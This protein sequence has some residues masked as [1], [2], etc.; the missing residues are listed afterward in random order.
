MSVS[1]ACG[2]KT[3][4]APNSL[5]Q[6]MNLLYLRKTH[7]FNNELRYAISLMYLEINVGLIDEEDP[8]RPTI[9]LVYHTGT[10]VKFVFRGQTRS[11]RNP[12]ICSQWQGY[13]NVRVHQV[14]IT[15]LDGCLLRRVQ[16]IPSRVC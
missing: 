6:F 4:A 16:I 8:Q 10:N 13:R 3:I 15:C 9:V 12:A 5:I 7:L 11:W 1:G 2:T 14:S